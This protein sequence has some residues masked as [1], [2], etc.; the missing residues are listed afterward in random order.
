MPEIKMPAAN[1][2]ETVFRLFVSGNSL[3]DAVKTAA[4]HVKNASADYCASHGI[5]LSNLTINLQRALPE[6]NGYRLTYAIAH[7]ATGKTPSSSN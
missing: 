5:E 6:K 3:Q 1:I 7:K 4:A 2:T